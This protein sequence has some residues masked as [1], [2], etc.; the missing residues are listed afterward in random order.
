MVQDIVVGPEL[1]HYTELVSTRP[2]GIVV[3]APRAD[4]V[5]AREAARGKSGYGEWTVADMDREMRATTPRLG[6][7]LDSSDQTVEE[8][9]TETLDRLP[10]TIVG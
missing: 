9:V 8:T 6:L 7:W 4:A 2:L 1:V 10:E 3:L 5:A